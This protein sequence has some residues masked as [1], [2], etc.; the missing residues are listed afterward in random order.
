M[1]ADRPA[2]LGGGGC[3]EILFILDPLDELKPWKD[4]SIA[5]MRALAQ[6]G[7]RLW[8]CTPQDLHWHAGIVGALVR[9]LRLSDKP[10]AGHTLGTWYE[11][12][13]S[14]APAE[15]HG[16]QDFD[17]VLMRK[18]PPFDS[19]YLHTTHLLS[20]AQR[21]G[22]RVFND[23]A[24]LRNH[25]EKLAITE[26]LQFIAPTLV[27]SNAQEIL[28]FQSHHGEIVVKP[29]DGMGGSG[30]FRVRPGDPNTNVILE[31]ATLDGSRTV[32]AQK[33][34]PQIAQ[35]D[36]RVLLIGG[37]AVPFCLARIPKEGE[38]R[39]NLAAGGTGR[40]QELSPRDREIAEALAPVLFERGLLLV[41]LD[42]IGECLTEINVTSPTC[43][44]EIQEQTGFDVAA[45]FVDA[46]EQRL[47]N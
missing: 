42:V 27:T 18:D 26:F 32:M 29:L 16:L 43:F 10:V 30:I 11:A 24:A 5:M 22:A 40:A 23:P 46:L 25:N 19:E 33:F 15:R 44:V 31:T 41:G 1:P 38:S 20:A 9:E 39:G 45:A 2:R 3:R 4:S 13:T 47:E 7:Y 35:G 6:R 37:K 34:L 12:P 8:A 28:L 14:G 36:K 21:A 17:A